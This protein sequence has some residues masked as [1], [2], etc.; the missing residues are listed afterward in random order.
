MSSLRLLW[1]DYSVSQG[2]PPLV[3]GLGSLGRSYNVSQGSLLLMLSLGL[4]C[5]P[6]LA[7]AC[8]KLGATWENMKWEPR[9]SAMCGGSGA[10]WKRL[11]SGQVDWVGLDLK[12]NGRARQKVLTTLMDRDRFGAVYAGPVKGKKSSTKERNNCAH[13]WFYPQR[14]FPPI[15]VPSPRVFYASFHGDGGNPFIYFEEF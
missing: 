15:P 2:S 1:K 4:Q 9:L 11:Q 8:A 13:R 6:R 7:T 14:E 10:T 5:E 3:L 12:R